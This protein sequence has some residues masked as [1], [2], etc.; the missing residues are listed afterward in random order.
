MNIPKKIKTLSKEHKKNISLALFGK[1]KSEEHKRNISI[2]K[3][4]GGSFKHHGYNMVWSG[5]KYVKEHRYLIEQSLGRKLYFWET[6]HHINGIKDDNRIENL[7]L[8]PNGEHNTMIQK[9]YQENLALKKEIDLLK[10]FGAV[11]DKI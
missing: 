11:K 4:K 6:I 10:S 8:L 1:N 2:A 3:W 9:I 5:E 7:Q